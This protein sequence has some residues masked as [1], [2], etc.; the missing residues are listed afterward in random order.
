MIGIKALDWAWIG[1]F[2]DGTKKR[3]NQQLME[4]KEPS[5]ISTE[6][7]KMFQDKARAAIKGELDVDSVKLEIPLNVNLII[8]KAPNE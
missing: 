8:G 3:I 6:K 5:D 2:I 7:A 4:L 1:G